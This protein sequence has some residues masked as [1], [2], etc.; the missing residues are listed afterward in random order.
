MRCVGDHKRVTL[1]DN[2]VVETSEGY[3]M[4]I[5]QSSCHLELNQLKKNVLGG[6]LITSSS[7]FISPQ[8]STSPNPAHNKSNYNHQMSANPRSEKINSQRRFSVEDEMVIAEEPLDTARSFG[9][10]DKK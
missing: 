6:L 3:G 2:Y 10:E 1:I 4:I 7:T 8:H 9:G 5:D